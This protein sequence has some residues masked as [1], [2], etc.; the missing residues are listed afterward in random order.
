MDDR[1]LSDPQ[2]TA[3]AIR[4]FTTINQG[5]AAFFGLTGLTSKTLL[6]PALERRSARPP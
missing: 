1:C 4:W 5:L 6:R 3:H 2:C